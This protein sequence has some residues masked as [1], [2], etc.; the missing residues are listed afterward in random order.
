ME[1]TAEF[2]TLDKCYENG[3]KIDVEDQALCIYQMK[4]GAVGTMR[5]SWVC[6]GQEDNSTIIYGSDGVMKIYCD[7][8]YSLQIEK[9]DGFDPV[10]VR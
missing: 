4:H 1:V 10:P 3:E 8:R 5:A 6:Y 2:S 7:P 9:K